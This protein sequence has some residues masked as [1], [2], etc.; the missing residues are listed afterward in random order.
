[1]YLERV[2][3]YFEANDIAD[4]RRKAALLSLIGPDTFNLLRSLL[5]PH[6]PADCSYDELKESLSAHFCP[7]RSQVFYRS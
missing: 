3:Y 1:M 2:E 7:K 6:T 4:G 5:V